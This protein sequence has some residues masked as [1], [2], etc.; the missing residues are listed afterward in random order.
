MDPKAL[1]GLL[2]DAV[3]QAVGTDGKR[4]IRLHMAKGTLD[5]R[6]ASDASLVLEFAPSE[7]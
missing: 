2:T 1:S 4:W 5:I 6:V 7:Q 3:I